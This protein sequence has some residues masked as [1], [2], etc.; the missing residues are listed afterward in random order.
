MLHSCMHALQ[1]GRQAGKRAE[2]IPYY[3]CTNVLNYQ[4]YPAYPLTY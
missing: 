2:N 1:A 4:S 3:V